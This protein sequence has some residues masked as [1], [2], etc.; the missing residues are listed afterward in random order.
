MSC[1]QIFLLEQLLRLDFRLNPYELRVSDTPPTCFLLFLPTATGVV[2]DTIPAHTIQSRCQDTDIARCSGQFWA[3]R[4]FPG[5]LAAMHPTLSVSVPMFCSTTKGFLVGFQR[6]LGLF[7]YDD[8]L[9]WMCICGLCEGMI[10]VARLMFA[11]AGAKKRRRRLDQAICTC[12]R[13][14]IM[15]RVSRSPHHVT[16]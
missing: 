14:A 2:W 13:W 11:P 16:L 9:F 3:I 5:T 7:T 1:F 15:S 10:V 8:F 6:I 12:K 4:L